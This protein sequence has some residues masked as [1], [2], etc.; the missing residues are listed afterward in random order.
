MCLTVGKGLSMYTFLK[1]LLLFGY[2]CSVD[3]LLK[4]M[5]FLFDRENVIPS[6]QTKTWN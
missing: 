6:V 4:A 2:G 3:L 1:V 5:L